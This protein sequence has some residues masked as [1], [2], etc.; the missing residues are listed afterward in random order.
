MCNLNGSILVQCFVTKY[1]NI[2]KSTKRDFSFFHS[3]CDAAPYNTRINSM[4]VCFVRLFSKGDCSSMLCKLSLTD[5]LS[6][7]VI[8]RFNE[9]IVRHNVAGA[10]PYHA[11]KLSYCH[12]DCVTCSETMTGGRGVVYSQVKMFCLCWYFLFLYIFYI[13]VALP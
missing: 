8:S 6:S 7:P 10:F 5:F 12:K 3:Q 9:S 13:F 4:C 11:V 2:S 1:C